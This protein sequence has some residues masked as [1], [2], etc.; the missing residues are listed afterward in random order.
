MRLLSEEEE[1]E[2]DVW[3]GGEGL[4]APPPFSSLLPNPTYRQAKGREKRLPLYSAHLACWKKKK[5]GMGGGEPPIDSMGA[6]VSVTPPLPR[7][8]SPPAYS[9]LRRR[10]CFGMGKRGKRSGERA[11]GTQGGESSWQT[12][13]P[14]S[15][16]RWSPEKPFVR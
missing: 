12:S 7:S 9:R 5:E 8:R 13:P 6:K 1:E 10:C 4:F 2:E 11:P 3:C 16:L 14:C 15:S